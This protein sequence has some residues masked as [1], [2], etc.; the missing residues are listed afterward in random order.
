MPPHCTQQEADSR[1]P[2]LEL[3]QHASEL[4]WLELVLFLRRTITNTKT[5]MSSFYKS[6][7]WNT[8]NI[9]FTFMKIF[10]KWGIVILVQSMTKVRFF[11]SF[12]SHTHRRM[13]VPG[14]GIESEPP[15]RP[16]QILNP[17]CQSGNF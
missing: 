5:E 2:A 16:H 14:P 11:F 15:Q 17:P 9:N 13:E 7:Q 12:F 3:G 6:M 4:S 8:V 1:F 10:N